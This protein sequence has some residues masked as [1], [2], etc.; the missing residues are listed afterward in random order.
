MGVPWGPY[1]HPHLFGILDIHHEIVH[2]L[3][4]LVKLQLPGHHGHQQGCAA[5]PLWAQQVLWHEA[6]PPTPSLNP[7]NSHRRQAQYPQLTDKQTGSERRAKVPAQNGGA[8]IINRLRTRPNLMCS[9]H[10][11]RMASCIRG[12]I[13]GARGRLGSEPGA[14]LWV[15][16]ADM[17][18]H[19]IVEGVPP[20]PTSTAFS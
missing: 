6:V 2:V 19:C 5:D 4:C 10:T 20:S 15:L 11:R 14:G 13:G 1:A 17:V 8:R 3:F 9:I 7:P 16:T 12:M 18:G